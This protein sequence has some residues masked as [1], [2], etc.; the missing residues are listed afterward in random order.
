M[1]KLVCILLAL[2]MALGCAA[3]C[4]E[5]SDDTEKTSLLV[6]R[7][8]EGDDP[9]PVY[10]KKEDEEAAALLEPGC[11][12]GLVRDLTEQGENWFHIVYMNEKKEGAA[13]YVAADR[14]KILTLGEF[15]K[16]MQDSDKANEMM[17]LMDAVEAY[18]QAA[19]GNQAAGNAATGSS[20]DFSQTKK[21]SEFYNA[22][23]DALKEI[24]GLDFSGELEQITAMGE[25]I[26]EK[27]AGA[28]ADLL[29]TA[30]DAAGRI[31]EAAGEELEGQM[32]EKLPDLIDKAAGMAE[33]V[34]DA[35][36]DKARDVIGEAEEKFGQ[37]GDGKLPETVD[38]MIGV[39]DETLEK[40]RNTETGLPE[41]D[42]DAFRDQM[43]DLNDKLG[44][45]AGDAGSA[46]M[47]KMNGLLDQAKNALG[48]GEMASGMIQG[49]TDVY[50]ENGFLAATDS[51]LNAIRAL[52]GDG[53]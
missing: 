17:D 3:V 10:E 36:A 15:K 25:E 30:A 24:A 32:D 21:I 51:L 14:A 29:D 20:T 53:D 47:E 2:T 4:A 39:L 7:G 42:A 48:Y 13:G 44:D 38:E 34:L 9:A 18:L 49:L 41:I 11:L 40:I 12:C 27:A 28:G 6:I 26:A 37:L 22:A 23:M 19:D 16:L 31:I 46:L 33:D 8:E 43:K 35:A 50:R 52:I 5:E 1:K 45:A